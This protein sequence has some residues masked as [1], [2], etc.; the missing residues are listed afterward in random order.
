MASHLEENRESSIEEK[1][2]NRSDDRQGTVSKGSRSPLRLLLIITISIFVIEAVLMFALSYI[3]PVSTTALILIDSFLLIA[4]VFPALYFFVFRPLV[5]NISER[6]LAE[7]E[8]KIFAENLEQNVAE[9]T[10]ELKESNQLKELF[11]DI[12]HHDLLNPTGV[13]RNYA[14]LLFEDAKDEEQ[15]ECALRIIS[16]AERLMEMIEDA[17]KLAK[18]DSSKEF[19]YEELD[20]NELFREVAVGFQPMLKK[21]EL[22]L[23]YGL[24]GECVAEVSPVI[25]DVFSNLMSNAIKYSPKGGKIEI[26]IADENGKYRIYVKD[27]GEGIK[28]ADKSRIFGRFKRIKKEGVKGSG[29]GLSIAKRIMDIHGGEIWVEDNPEGGS[30]FNFEIPKFR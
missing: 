6:E 5:R 23:E 8:L 16:S 14:E 24:W 15:R 26:G 13:I 17:S 19:K 7:E 12:M 18:L 30:V 25:E 4:L 20:L 11:T 28:E 1:T 10:Q 2:L 27:W 21:K 29:L 3:P 22:K 9:R